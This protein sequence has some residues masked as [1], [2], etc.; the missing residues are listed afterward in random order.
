MARQSLRVLARLVARVAHLHHQLVVT[1]AAL[2]PWMSTWQL[3]IH[4]RLAIAAIASWHARRRTGSA[5][6]VVSLHAPV[7]HWVRIRI[8][9]H[10]HFA[11]P[12]YACDVV[13]VAVEAGVAGDGGTVLRFIDEWIGGPAAVSG[14]VAHRWHELAVEV[15]HVCVVEEWG[16]GR[17]GTV[18]A[19]AV[20]MLLMEA[21]VRVIDSSMRVVLSL[22]VWVLVPSSPELEIFVVV[23]LVWPLAWRKIVWRLLMLTGHRQGTMPVLRVSEGRCLGL[24][25]SAVRVTAAVRVTL[26]TRLHLA[27]A[28]HVLGRERIWPSSVCRG[29]LKIQVADLRASRGVGLRWTASRICSM[30]LGGISRLI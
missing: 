13:D 18:G 25:S 27:E 11:A 4:V 20:A 10:C 22:T 8:I 23:L 12:G 16:I 9:D 2:V 1:E 28:S 5:A 15:A 29:V 30:M 26:R 17:I 3:V 19:V 6:L 21:W 24:C 14:Q 7:Q